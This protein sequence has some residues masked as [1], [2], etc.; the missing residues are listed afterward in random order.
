[1]YSCWQWRVGSEQNCLHSFNSEVMIVFVCY[2]SA[3]VT[4]PQVCVYRVV[5]MN[6]LFNVV[7]T[8]PHSHP[9]LCLSKTGSVRNPLIYTGCVC[10][11]RKLR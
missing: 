6:R 7:V 10:E 11:T 3:V 4:P 9:L 5:V 2:T 8:P 1:M